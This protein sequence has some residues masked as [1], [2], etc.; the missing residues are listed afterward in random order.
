MKRSACSIAART[1]AHMQVEGYTGA[2]QPSLAPGRVEKRARVC[3]YVTLDVGRVDGDLGADPGRPARTRAQNLGVARPLGCQRG[4]CAVFIGDGEQKRN[5]RIR[6][7][8]EGGHAPNGTQRATLTR[9]CSAPRLGPVMRTFRLLDEVPALDK[10]PR[11]IACGL[12]SH[13]HCHV[14]PRHPRHCDGRTYSAADHAGRAGCRCKF[15]GP[16]SCPSPAPRL[17]PAPARP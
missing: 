11:N 7:G 4:V 9:A 16:V 6:L 3:C 8:C 2:C 5:G 13:L 1:D 15:P 17:D 10:V 12:A 14:V